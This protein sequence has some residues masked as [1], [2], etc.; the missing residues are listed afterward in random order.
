MRGEEEKQPK[1]ALKT[2]LAKINVCTTVEGLT[3][4]MMDN[5]VVTPSNGKIK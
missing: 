1:F 4:K 2:T 3:R 5:P